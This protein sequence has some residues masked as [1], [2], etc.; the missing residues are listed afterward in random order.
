MRHA[1]ATFLT[2][3]LLWLLFTQANHLLSGLRVYL[4]VGGLF[5]TYAALMLP[6]RAGLAVVLLGGMLCDAT[7][8]VRFGTHLLLFAAAFAVLS[9]LRDRL[10]REDPMARLLIALLAN[11]ALFLLFSF[12]QIGGSP[13]PTVAWPRIIMDLVCSQVALVIVAPWFFALQRRALLLAHAEREAL[14]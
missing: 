1:L 12:T 11:L 5:V 6:S 13:V 2:L 8:P 9:H 3:L 10:P 4:W 7:T 14:D